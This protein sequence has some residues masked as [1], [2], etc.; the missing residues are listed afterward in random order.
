MKEVVMKTISWILLFSLIFYCCTPTY[1][2]RHNPSDYLKL[3]QAL[4]EKKASITLINDTVIVGENVYVGLD[5]T[6]WLERASTGESTTA[7]TVPTWAVKHVEFRSPLEGA[8]IYVILGALIIGA[9][10][11]FY[12]NA[13]EENSGSEAWAAYL[14]AY[15]GGICGAIFLIGGIGGSLVGDLERYTLTA[16]EDSTD[17]STEINQYFEE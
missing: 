9:S 5:S 10:L 8:A 1:T 17:I 7:R 4:D 6:S 2:I 11:I 12:Y 15:L 16:S 14:I 3:N 13:K